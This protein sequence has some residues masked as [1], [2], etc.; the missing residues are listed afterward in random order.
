[1]LEANAMMRV[2]CRQLNALTAVVVEAVD[3]EE[4]ETRRRGT[5]GFIYAGRGRLCAVRSWVTIS[6]PEDHTRTDALCVIGLETRSEGDSVIWRARQEGAWAKTRQ[7]RGTS[8]ALEIM[9]TTGRFG[10]VH[11]RCGIGCLPRQA[12]VCDIERRV[13][14]VEDGLR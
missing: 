14:G 4:K 9:Q 1:M 7:Q 6:E 3:G 10:D 5:E 11:W 12:Q 2:E 8:L 13:G